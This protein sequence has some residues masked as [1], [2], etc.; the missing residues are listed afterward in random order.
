MVDAVHSF[1]E[2]KSA[3]TKYNDVVSMFLFMQYGIIMVMLIAV[4]LKYRVSEFYL[5]LLAAVFVDLYG[6]VDRIHIQR[7][8]ETRSIEM[9]LMMKNVS[10]I[11]NG[12]SAPSQKGV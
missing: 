8:Y 12:V 11:H 4:F 5:T 2:L 3:K 1:P 7:I 10:N 6:V 9:E